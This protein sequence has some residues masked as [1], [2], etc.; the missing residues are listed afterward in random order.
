MAN[1][2]TRIL[3]IEDEGAHAEAI[4]RSLEN[5]AG[6][7]LRVMGSLK[8]FQDEAAAWNPDMVLMDLNLPDG[9]ATD[10][11]PDP[12]DSRPFPVI[13]MT[14]YGSEVTAVEALKSGAFDYLV[15]SP[16]TF[17]GLPRTLERLFR[18]WHL[19]A[20][21]KRMDHELRASEAKFRSL[22][23]SSTDF[24]MR[25]D[26]QGRHTYLNP[27]ALE[28]LDMKGADILGKT[29][30]EC[31]FPEELCRF[32][33]ARI[34]Q[35]IETGQPSQLEFEFEGPH[36]LATHD[37]RL[38]PEFDA[39]GSVYSVLGVSRD[40]TERKRAEVALRESQESLAGLFE[41][42]VLGLYRTTVEG[43]PLMANKALCKMFGYESFEELAKADEH[44]PR[45][46]HEVNPTYSRARF[47]KE[48][49]E[50]GRVVGLESVWT[51]ANG[52]RVTLRENARAVRDVAGNLLYFEG[53]F[54]DITEQ[55]RVE[56]ALRASKELFTK[57][58]ATSPDAIAINRQEDGV[59]IAINE[60]FTRMS[61]YSEADV[62]GRSAVG[63]PLSLWV[64]LKD[65]ER[66]IA[67]LKDK[68][69]VTDL[70]AAFRMKDGRQITGLMSAKLLEIKGETTILSITRDISERKQAEV[71]LRESEGRFRELLESVDFVAVQGY[72]SDGTTQYWNRASERLYGYSP[73]EAIGRN[74]LDLIIP[75]EMRSEVKCAIQKMRETGQTIPSSEL[76]LMRKDGSRVPVYSSHAIVN[77]PGRPPE[78][79]C[80]D[81]DLTERKLVEEQQ[82]HLQAQLQ[83]AQKMESLGSLAGGVAHDMNNVL[84]AILGLASAHLELQPVDSPAHRAFDTISQAAIRGGKMVKSLLSFARQSPAEALELDMNAIL[85]EEV[86]L[87][88][89]TTLAKVRLEMELAPDL[90]PVRGDASALT[91]AFMNL[92]VNAVDAMPEHGTLTLR[93]RNVDSEWIEV[94]V[95]DTGIGMPK[96]ILEK[97]LDP[98]FTTKEPGKGTGLGLSMVYSTVKAHQ[99]QLEIQSEPGR[100][101][102][103]RLRFPAC[104][105]PP[106][107]A[108]APAGV[109]TEA[110]P[111]GLN[112]LLVDD[113]ELIQS[114]MQAILEVLG[115]R[116]T[117]VCSGEEALA[118]LEGGV[119]CDVVILDMNMPGLGGAGTLP[120]LRALRPTLPVLLATGRAD[121]TAL[122][123]IE[124]HSNLTL[125]SKP[126]TIK[127]LQ[128]YLQGLGRRGISDWNP[129]V[130]P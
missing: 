55:K 7:E 4:L 94:M 86:H 21:G 24:I 47:R 11:L 48:I 99:G 34:Q 89:R 10:V 129:T 30:L 39:K 69:E 119:R 14:S 123:L 109:Q 42:A 115:H 118:R 100:G 3:I 15:K 127:E 59:Y 107:A 114:S 97:A 106:Q 58:F 56:E 112:V 96:E 64:D 63:E 124:A 53:I 120:R 126:F 20:E 13:V 61:G 116:A 26:R 67:G 102:C 9:R 77:V 19:R 18:E 49:E 87:L 117:G 76:L 92:C 62:L 37:W 103:V 121:Q 95:E 23:E 104:E 105:V 98:F 68:G 81:I 50:K 54:E 88:E 113:D 8:E 31:G 93:T 12:T 38:T 46:D 83:Q 32:W 41:H 29:H 108:E 91:H 82:R 110:P 66:L 73:E 44:S 85:R 6:A 43:R 27:A 28:M 22:A 33:E 75:V 35:V 52:E 90:R 80:M 60:G 57:A 51:K 25:Y 17:Q 40:I 79:F 72:G 130:I 78:M 70:E 71:A 101:T 45:V 122:D 36:G 111:G 128:G 1:P 125:L 16:E 2:S 84:G 65:R 74:L 5:V